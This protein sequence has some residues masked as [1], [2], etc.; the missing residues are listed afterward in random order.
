MSLCG[1]LPGPLSWTETC[2][3]SE[4]TTTVATLGII[5]MGYTGQQQ[6][7]AAAS[8]QGLEPVVATDVNPQCLEHLPDGLRA[9]SDW[10]QILDDDGVEAV[11]LCLPHDAHEEVALAA[12]ARGKHLLI[13]KPLAIDL[14]GAE[15]IAAAAAA[16]DRVVMVEMTHRFYPPMRAARGLV[17]SGRLGAIYAVED[18]IMQF[19]Q[20]G[21][22]PSWMLDRRHAGGG[23]ALTNGV[24]MLDRIA[25]LCGQPLTLVSGRAGWSHG[26]G[27]IE[28]TAAMLL[29]LADG[30]PAHL[31]ASWAVVPQPGADRGDAAARAVPGQTS[32]GDARALRGDMDDELTLYGTG[33][34]LRVWSWDGWAFEPSDGPPEEHVGFPAEMERSARVR[35]AMTAALEEFSTAI[36]CG[37]PASPGAD[38]ILQV[39]R[40]LDQFYR[41][42][43]VAD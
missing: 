20:R 11:T 38:E 4:G 15:R 16:S 30:T 1:G 43:G 18:R 32:L 29:C 8:V 9:A 19:V 13:E 40:L 42:V 25:W 33:G 21:M 36:H 34:T 3:T 31:L 24:H 14:A 6:V 2:L 39:H 7:L 23:V 35:L 17:E 41:A 37:R 10:Q 12:L 28:D 22:L 26:L 5:G 27:D